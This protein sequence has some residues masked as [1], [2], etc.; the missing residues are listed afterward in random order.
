MTSSGRQRPN[1]PRTSSVRRF[2]QTLMPLL[3]ELSGG[4]GMRRREGT[5]YRRSIYNSIR[6][7]VGEGL[8]E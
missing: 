5:R 4:D 2:H 8:E 3:T 7:A 1:Q 6:D